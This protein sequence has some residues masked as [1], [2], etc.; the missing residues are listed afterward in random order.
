MAIGLA[1]IG[2]MREAENILVLLLIVIDSNM[3][4]VENKYRQFK[5]DVMFDY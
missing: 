3:A 5:S 1:S 4:L 2:A